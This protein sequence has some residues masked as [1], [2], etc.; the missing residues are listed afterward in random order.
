MKE[1]PSG[2]RKMPQ[3][4]FGD[5]GRPSVSSWSHTTASG[6]ALL[7]FTPSALIETDSY[8]NEHRAR[9]SSLTI[10]PHSISDQLDA[11]TGQQKHT[12]SPTQSKTCAEEISETYWVENGCLRDLSQRIVSKWDLWLWFSA[13]S[14]FFLCNTKQDGLWQSIRSNV[15]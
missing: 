12:P 10:P 13:L 14:I 9:P 2:H 3:C 11:D 7:P 15:T 6:L 5:G 1:D 4:W 8:R